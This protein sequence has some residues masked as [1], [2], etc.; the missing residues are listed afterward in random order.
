[1]SPSLSL[2]SQISTPGVG[3]AAARSVIVK[4]RRH[5]AQKKQRRIP[6]TI[7]RS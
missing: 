3:Q 7:A 4:R 5:V 6:E 2:P 1:M